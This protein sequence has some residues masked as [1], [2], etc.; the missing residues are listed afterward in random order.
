MADMETGSNTGGHLFTREEL[1]GSYNLK[2][3]EWLFIDPEIWY[4]N[5]QAPDDNINTTAATTYIA[6]RMDDY[7]DP[8]IGYYDLFGEFSYEFKGW[9][10][11]MFNRAHPAYTKELKRILHLKGVYTGPANIPTPEALFRLV[12]SEDCPQWPDEQL[13]HGV[14]DKDSV[15][16]I[17]QQ[18]LK[19][20]Q[21][22]LGP[23][24]VNRAP[25]RRQQGQ[26]SAS[27]LPK[28]SQHTPS[29]HT[30]Q[31]D[32]SQQAVKC[33]PSFQYQEI[34]NCEVYT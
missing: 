12:N 26:Q 5:V 18:R 23:I 9:T 13:L 3:R 17:L 8:R 30:P 6:Y 20:G 22:T 29:T 24:P 2:K 7:I 14:F 33:E 19:Q 34:A 10:E 16:Y 1:L 25:R 31:P 4:N 28:T 27:Q 21:R 11:S 15:P 32:Q